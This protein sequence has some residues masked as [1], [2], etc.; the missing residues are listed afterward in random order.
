MSRTSAYRL[1]VRTDSADGEALILLA[2]GELVATLVELKDEGHGEARGQWAVEAL[3]GLKERL[4]SSSF[5]SVREAADWVSR[6]IGSPPFAIDG[7][8][9]R[10]E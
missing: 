6:H 4:P 7:P 2:D 5:G 8:L 3:Y 10:L 9:E 1:R